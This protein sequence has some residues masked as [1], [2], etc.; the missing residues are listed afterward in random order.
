MGGEA[1]TLA[2]FEDA[3][4]NIETRLDIAAD[5][6]EAAR[7]QLKSLRALANRTL[8]ND[9]PCGDAYERRLRAQH[10]PA[11][12]VAEAMLEPVPAGVEMW[13]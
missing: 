6:I 4:A 3:Q 7:R 10:I 5:E 13:Q 1:M 12:D 11:D 9:V 2:E 8:D